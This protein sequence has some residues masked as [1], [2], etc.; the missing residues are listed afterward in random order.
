[1]IRS[2]RLGFAAAAVVLGLSACGHTGPSTTVAKT[3]AVIHVGASHNTGKGG[4]PTADTSMMPYQDVTYVFD[5]TPGD[6]GATGSAWSLPS[7]QQPDL[8][9]V[10]RIATLLGVK[11]DVTALPADQGGGWRVGPADGSAPTLTVGTDGM[12]SWWYNPAAST[13]GSVGCGT[14]SSSST[15][16][17]TSGGTD[18]VAPVPPDSIP[19]P[20]TVDPD[21]PSTTVMPCETPTPPA[22]VPTAA[23][24]LAKAKQLVTGMGYD[25]AQY[26]FDTSADQWGAQVTG[27]L[28]LGGHRSPLTVSFGFGAEGALTW[29][30][31]TLATPQPAAEYPLVSVQVALDRLNDHSGKWLFYGYPGVRAMNGGIAVDDVATAIPPAN[32]TSGS[33]GAPAPGTPTPTTMVVVGSDGTTSVSLVT[34]GPSVAPTCPADGNCVTD[35]PVTVQPVTVHLNGVHLD[36]T[37]VWA[38]DGTVWLLP[39][40]TFTDGNGGQYTVIAVDEAYLDLPGA[41]TPDTTPVTGDTK[42][43]SEPVTTVPSN[44]VPSNTVPFTTGIVNPGGPI[45]TALPDRPTGTA[46]VSS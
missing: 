31:G 22:N 8:A 19:T 9:R 39:A 36:I 27:Y 24:A 16:G 3:P 29:S 18:V 33:G 21:A 44:T 35:P 5:G 41:V 6:L 2:R 38:Q 37:A 32:A 17:G 4:A 40:Y 13:P 20:E 1:M 11:G 42:P 30:S 25:V 12:L 46:T 34:G 43:G 10:Q 28:Q 7:G 23:E 14:V 45:V 15:G 26:A